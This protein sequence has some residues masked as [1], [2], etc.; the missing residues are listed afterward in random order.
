M[1]APQVI[2]LV[3]LGIELLYTAHM[4]GKPKEERYNFF[5][6]FVGAL[7]TFGLLAWG[8]FFK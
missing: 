2:F 7:I 3:L 8:G 6:T 5:V 4:H 1:N